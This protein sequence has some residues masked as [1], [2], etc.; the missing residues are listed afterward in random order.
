MVEQVWKPVSIKQ[1]TDQQGMVE[2]VW[3]PVS[4]KQIT[5]QQGMVEQVWKPV[6]MKS[7]KVQT[8]SIPTH[9]RDIS[10]DD[11]Y[12]VE[13]CT[14]IRISRQCGTKWPTY[15]SVAML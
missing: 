13:D 2:Q 3:K 4:I 6:S 10:T 5:D 14:S 15:F 7:T 1:I 12:Y 9:V 11:I 8:L